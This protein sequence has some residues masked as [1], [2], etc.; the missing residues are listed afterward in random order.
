[1]RAFAERAGLGE[2]GKRHHVGRVGIAKFEDLR[3]RR[4]SLD[5]YTASF[6]NH[7]RH[8]R[9][10]EKTPAR[11][12][13]VR[14]LQKQSNRLTRVH[15][16]RERFVAHWRGLTKRG[17]RRDLWHKPARLIEGLSELSL[18]RRQS[19]PDD[20]VEGMHLPYARHSDW[21]DRRL[22]WTH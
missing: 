4:G 14:R 18:P 17:Q 11:L 13:L 7:F 12:R 3:H 21:S 9:A 10:G 2:R 15:E 16:P 6:V 1:M 22:A 20:V 5:R 19:L 8:R